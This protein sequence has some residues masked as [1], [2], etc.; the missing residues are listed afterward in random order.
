MVDNVWIRGG[1]GFNGMGEGRGER[2]KELPQLT[3]HQ[4]DAATFWFWN[5]ITERTFWKELSGKWMATVS[6][7]NK[8]KMVE[9][10]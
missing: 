5:E 10:D 9:K 3:G 2:D 6:N 4:I 7:K 1:Q 8:L